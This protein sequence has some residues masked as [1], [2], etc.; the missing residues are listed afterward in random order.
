V[1][2]GGWTAVHVRTARDRAAVIRTLFEHGAEGVQETD[3]EV[4]TQMRSPDLTALATALVHADSTAELVTSAAP[5]VDWTVE[6]RKHLK[7]RRV[8][9]LVVTP[10]WFA[11][12]YTAAERIVIEPGMGFGTG[13]HETTRGV[14]RLMPAVLKPGD[15]VADLGS[16]S[17]VLAI[18]AAK[19]GA[20]HAYAIEMDPDAMGNAAENV[21]LNGVGDRVTLMEG[22]AFALLPFVAPVQLVL[23]NIVTPVLVELLPHI[24]TA[25][26]P[27]GRAILSGIL[28]E[29]SQRIRDAVASGGWTIA[30]VD[31]EGLWWSVAICRV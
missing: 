27:S 6:W 18:A 7:A 1:S 5:D 30:A 17:G 19:L 15:V 20:R 12:D 26:G 14:M 11:D 31:E 10:P 25:V 4:V 9:Q 8:G 13:D 3:T 2:A 22:D 28:V 21:A 24:A 16:G 29:E 23:A